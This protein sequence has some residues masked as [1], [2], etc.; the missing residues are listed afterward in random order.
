MSHGDSLSLFSVC[1]ASCSVMVPRG[2][3]DCLFPGE[4]LRTTINLYAKRQYL[5]WILETHIGGDN[6]NNNHNN[7]NNN[8]V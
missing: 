4:T 2:A 1:F 3:S 8:N 6:N 5:E 7:N